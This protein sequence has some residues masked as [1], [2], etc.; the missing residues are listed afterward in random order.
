M[1]IHS[2]AKVVMLYIILMCISCFM[3][4]FTNDILLAVHFMF[5]LD[6]RNDVRQKANLSNFFFFFFL[7]SKLGHGRKAVETIHNISYSLGPG[8]AKKLI[9]Q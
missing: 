6:C 3:C 2:L 1:G 9:V 5:I 4:F 7:S 8:T